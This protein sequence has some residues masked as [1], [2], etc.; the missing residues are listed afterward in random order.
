METNQN[1]EIIL[2]SGGLD[3]P[4]YSKPPAVLLYGLLLSQASEVLLK[5]LAGSIGK[6]SCQ[7]ASECRY[8]KQGDEVCPGFKGLE[9]WLSQSQLCQPAAGLHTVGQSVSRYFCCSSRLLSVGQCTGVPHSKAVCKALQS[10]GAAEAST[11]HGCGRGLRYTQP[12]V[13]AG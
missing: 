3:T 5:V 11:G 12:P 1:Q 9:C 4:V 6:C 13:Q 8:Y 7:L 10:G 2:L